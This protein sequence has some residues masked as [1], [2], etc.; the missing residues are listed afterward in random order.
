MIPDI[1][2]CGPRRGGEK[3]KIHIRSIIYHAHDKWKNKWDDNARMRAHTHIHTP[4]VGRFPPYCRGWMSL[5][6]KLHVHIIRI[7]TQRVNMGATSAVVMP[8]NERSCFAESSVFSLRD[9][10]V[11]TCQRHACAIILDK[12]AQEIRGEGNILL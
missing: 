5:P 9:P 11:G 8:N 1:T 4:S 10:K 7:A 12:Y 2:V 6:S 3:N